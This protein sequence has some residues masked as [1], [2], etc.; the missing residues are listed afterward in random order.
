MRPLSAGLDR[1][2]RPE[3]HGYRSGRSPRTA[4]EQ[5]CARSRGRVARRVLAG[6]GV[7]GAVGPLAAW[8]ALEAVL[9]LRGQAVTRLLSAT[10][11]VELEGRGV[12]VRGLG[13]PVRCAVAETEDYTVVWTE[14]EC[15]S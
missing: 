3:V 8:G 1:R 11:R 5:L 6:L 9:K 12:A 2:L 7:D 10:P 4:I 13:D 15:T 14:G